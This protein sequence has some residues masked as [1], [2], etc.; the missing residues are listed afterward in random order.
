VGDLGR[1]R[2][3]RLQPPGEDLDDAGELGNPHHL[4]GRQVGNMG[5]ADE[6][7]HM[8]LAMGV[9]LDVAKHHQIVVAGHFLEGPG[10]RFDRVLLIALEELAIGIDHP[11]R[12]VEQAFPVRILASPGKERPD[13]R[14]GLC[15]A[16]P[17]DARAAPDK[18]LVRPD[19]LHHGI[20]RSCCPVLHWALQSEAPRVLV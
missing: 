9:E 11:L 10:Q 8:V 1:H 6:G 14:L 3:L 5:T 16:R 15:L 18:W 12:G 19:L 20:H 2:L 17:L 13:R 4:V 7:H